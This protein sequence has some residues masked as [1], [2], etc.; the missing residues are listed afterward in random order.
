MSARMRRPLSLGHTNLLCG[1]V[2]V[3]LGHGSD[4]GRAGVRDGGVDVRGTVVEG[5]GLAGAC[6]EQPAEDGCPE[7]GLESKH[8]ACV[9]LSWDEERG[10]S[11]RETGCRV[12]VQ[13]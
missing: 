8:G 9:V 6:R 3:A 4:G 2:E 7:G 11:L 13:E 1:S 5:S 10:E 12:G